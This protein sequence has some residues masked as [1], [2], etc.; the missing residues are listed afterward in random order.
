MEYVPLV[1]VLMCHVNP[2][3]SKHKRFLLLLGKHKTCARFQGKPLL[4]ASD[5][6]T[7]D[8]KWKLLSTVSVLVAGVSGVSQR[9][10]PENVRMFCVVLLTLTVPV[11]QYCAHKASRGYHIYVPKSGDY[12]VRTGNEKSTTFKLMNTWT[13]LLYSAKNCKNNWFRY[14]EVTGVFEDRDF[15]FGARVRKTVGARSYCILELLAL[16]GLRRAATL[17]AWFKKKSIYFFSC[18]NWKVARNGVLRGRRVS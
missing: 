1:T 7:S 8:G 12:F 11:S 15:T 10:Y 13:A 3:R 5:R 14:V 9:I 16:K 17:S 18:R 2:L 6:Q 4:Q